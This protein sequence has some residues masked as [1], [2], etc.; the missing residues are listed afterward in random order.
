MKFII[1]DWAGNEMFDLKFKSFDDAW[2]FLYEKFPDDHEKE[3][4]NQELQ[5]YYVEEA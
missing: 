4:D 5:E 1:K 3:E 2:E